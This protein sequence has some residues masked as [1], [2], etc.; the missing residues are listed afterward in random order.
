MIFSPQDHERMLSFWLYTAI[1]LGIVFA[2]FFL[3]S[4][5]PFG[6]EKTKPTPPPAPP[7]RTAEN[8]EG[9]SQVAS[10]IVDLGNK[11]DARG[12]IAKS[13]ESGTLKAAAETNLAYLGAPAKAVSADDVKVVDK[14]LS[15]MQRQEEQYRSDR[16]AWEAKIDSLSRQN[17]QY[18]VEV[19][20][21]GGIIA[22]LKFWLWLGVIGLAIACALI[23]GL[24]IFILK[25]IAGRAKA[26][27]VST[28]KAVQEFR[29]NN[30]EVAP[31]LDAALDKYQDKHEKAA[32]IDIKSELKKKAS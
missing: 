6:T 1:A 20:T 17:E 29:E 2:V 24:W 19:T 13:T 32:I 11:A 7:Q 18:K 26:Q 10:L 31:A 14:L 5:A 27:L 21:M 22:K 15:S 16:A 30:R 9:A 4:C 23:P 25:F 28:V 3:S 8:K 12:I